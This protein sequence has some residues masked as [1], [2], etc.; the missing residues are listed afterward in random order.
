MF[1]FKRPSALL[2]LSIRTIVGPIFS[3]VIRVVTTLALVVL[4]LSNSETDRRP[5]A[6]YN[7]VVN[8]SYCW[9]EI[10]FNNLKVGMSYLYGENKL[11][12]L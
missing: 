12:F 11:F 2:M 10:R 6:G 1:T 9:I 5:R 7:T 8:R 3:G 4:S